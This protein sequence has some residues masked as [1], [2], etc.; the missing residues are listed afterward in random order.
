MKRDDLL[1]LNDV[2]QHPGRRLE[3]D[4]STELQEEGE[5]DLVSPLE[6]TLDAVST[7]NL[8]LI[9]GTFRTRA[10]VECARCGE[11]LEKDVAFEMDE[12]FPVEGV[13]SSYSSQDFARVTSDEP[14]AMFE[15]NTLMVEALLRQ[16]VLLS[17]PLQPL[18]PHGWEEPCPA[19]QAREAKARDRSAPAT[20]A[21]AKLSELLEPDEDAGP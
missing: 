7:G 4:I 6:G 12:Q 2:L 21:F 20:G 17:L 3:V 18:C 5:L 9:K 14:E 13:P 10:V 15:G 16:G 1:D 11:P 8:L 19:E